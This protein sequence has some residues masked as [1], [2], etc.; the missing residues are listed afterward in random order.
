MTETDIIF[1]LSMFIE[2]LAETNK[3]TSRGASRVPARGY[4]NFTI[5]IIACLEY[6]DL[7]ID[8]LPSD[9]KKRS[10]KMCISIRV[11]Q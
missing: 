8:F 7:T 1:N 6:S 11:N 5:L 3:P 9:E 4:P 2:I 10:Y